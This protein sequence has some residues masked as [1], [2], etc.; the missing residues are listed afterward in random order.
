MKLIGWQ[1]AVRSEDNNNVPGHRRDDHVGRL[2]DLLVEVHLP[3]P[4]QKGFSDGDHHHQTVSIYHVMFNI[5][6]LFTH[7]CRVNYYSSISE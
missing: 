4:D 2:E 1:M 7:A 6:F 3:V 5:R